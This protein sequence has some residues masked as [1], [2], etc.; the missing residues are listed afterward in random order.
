MEDKEIIEL[1]VS[2]SEEAISRLSKKYNTYCF[3]IA[4]PIQ[5]YVH[6]SLGAFHL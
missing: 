5:Q 3:A 6:G 1:F 2:R 4:F